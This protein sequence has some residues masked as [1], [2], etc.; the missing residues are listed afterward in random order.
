MSPQGTITHLITR[1]KQGDREAARGLWQ[2]YF[3]RLVTFASAR[4]HNAMG[5]ADEEGVWQRFA[6]NWAIAALKSVR[7]ASC[8]GQL[9]ARRR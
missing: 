1:L 3:H 4:L 5:L 8:D 9:P 7:T 6:T 2:A